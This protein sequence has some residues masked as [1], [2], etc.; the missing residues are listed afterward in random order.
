MP[1]LIIIFIKKAY[2]DY[3]IRLICINLIDKVSETATLMQ[4]LGFF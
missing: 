1:K 3:K 4:A 2:I